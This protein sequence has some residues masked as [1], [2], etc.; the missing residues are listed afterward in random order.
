MNSGRSKR[1]LILELGAVGHHPSYV[2]WLLESDL[3]KSANITLASRREMFEHP[4]IRD[5]AVP[6]TPHQIDVGPELQASLDDVS[7]AGLIRNSWI[8]GNLYRK[9]YFTLA[10]SAS[11]DFVIVA[12]LDYCLLGL[13]V[14]QE[15]FE[16]TPWMTITMR[17]M[18]HYGHMGVSAPQQ[19]LK[20]TIRRLLFYRILK[21]KSM[22]AIL[23]IDP[24]LA[25]FAAQQRNP[26][27]RKI[28][29]LADP[30]KHHSVL[31]PKAFAKR[32]LG[33]PEDA[34]VVLLYGEISRRKGVFSLVEAAANPACP[35]VVRVLLAG[36][37]SEPG[38]LV[39]S[40]AFQRLTAQGRIHIID[41]Y[42]DDEQERLVLAAADCM[43]VGYTDFYG[44]SSMMV[45]SGRHAVP[46][47][48]SQDGLIGHIARKF[49]IGV[50]IEP[51]N[52]PSV[53]AALI[54]LV[55]EPE[56]FV[57]AGRNGVT[58]FQKHRPTELQRLVTEKAV[59]SW[60]R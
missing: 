44:L 24:T 47:L 51:R 39:K 42:L 21:Q 19:K 3:S 18:F 12:F 1:V 13:A 2:R 57:R 58:V 17:T 31:P 9:A 36:R 45:L 5:C 59:Q 8:I 23:T 43:W 30:A 16:G 7:S 15:A 28:E 14:P 33:I 11:I 6:F 55:N 10:R 32:Q 22:I 20:T 52:P 38:E 40:E 4:A 53:V 41:G 48:A 25:E 56:F 60:T 34:R 35:L 46:V 54:R 50:I 49:E 37:N 26:V 29:Y 27:L